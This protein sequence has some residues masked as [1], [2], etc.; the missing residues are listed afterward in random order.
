MTRIEMHELKTQQ[1]QQTEQAEEALQYECALLQMCI[2]CWT[3]SA[4]F[5]DFDWFLWFLLIWLM[6][7]D[8]YWFWL[9][10]VI[11]YSFLPISI[12]CRDFWDLYWFWLTLVIFTDF[13]WF[14]RFPLIFLSDFDWYLRFPQISTKHHHLL[15]EH[16]VADEALGV[17]GRKV[18]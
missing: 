3:V 1:A 2:W 10:F 16:K 6:F 8:S 5:T 11:S 18:F 9:I 17:N 13:D 15:G 4:I 7:C 12:D 14:L